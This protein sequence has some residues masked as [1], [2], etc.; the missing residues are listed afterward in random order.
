LSKPVIAQ[1]QAGDIPALCTILNE[2][3][4]LGG[5]TANE[6]PFTAESFANEFGPGPDTIYCTVAHLGNAPVAFQHL[7]FYGKAQPGWGYISSFAAPA[8]QGHGI[9]AQLFAQT[10]AL[11]RDAGLLKINATIRADNQPGLRYYAK[12][13][14]V[15]YDRMLGVPLRDGTPVDRIKTAFAL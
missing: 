12:M 6:V 3:I 10:C 15:E 1:L 7:G 9:G 11:A 8:S 5:T 2:I 13:G 14:F 4:A